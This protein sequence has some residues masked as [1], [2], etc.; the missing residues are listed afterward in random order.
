[1]CIEALL[2]VLHKQE[3]KTSVLKIVQCNNTVNLFFHA[4]F[5]YKESVS[6]YRNMSSL[7]HPEI[8][9]REH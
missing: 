6:H 9:F 5:S 7:Q 2:L 1:M 8:I 4:D 3:G